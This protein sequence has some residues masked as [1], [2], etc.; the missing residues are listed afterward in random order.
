LLTCACVL[1]GCPADPKS[2]AAV[3][4][5]GTPDSASN[6]AAVSEHT[7][8]DSHNAKPDAG[9][10][11]PAMGGS[12]ADAGSSMTPPTGSEPKPGADAGRDQPKPPAADGGTPAADGGQPDPTGDAGSMLHEPVS[13]R[14]FLPTGEVQNTIRPQVEIDRAGGTH[15]LYPSYAGGDAYYAYC[16]KDCSGPDAMK[17]VRLPTDGTV[18]NA[19]LTLSAEGK[20]RALLATLLRVYYAQCDSDCSSAANWTVAAIVEHQGDQDVTGSALALDSAGHP[21]FLMHTYLAYLG[22][23]QKAPQTWFAQCDDACNTASSW[24]IDPIADQI[25]YGSQLRYDAQGRAHVA[26]GLVNADGNSGTDKLAAYFTC[27]DGCSSPD[28]WTGIGL[29]PLFESQSEEVRPSLAMALTKQ[30]GPRVVAL[31]HDANGQRRIVYLECDAACD[32]DHWASSVISDLKQLG[33]GVDIALDAQDHPHFAFTLDSNIGLYSCDASH[34]V[35]ETATWTLSK[36]EF[37][38]DLPHDDIILWPNCTI[39]AWVLQNPSVALG[40]DGSVRV[41]Y[42]ATDLSGGLSVIDPTKPACVAGKDMTLSRMAL[43]S[44]AL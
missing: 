18:G 21:R 32:D 41:A 26:T 12:K 36:I 42:E 15:A 2:T 28:A 7:S 17:V 9:H 27:A 4:D 31:D 1:A 34:C 6:D 44:S 22:I 43:L 40:G 25:W 38:S 11:Q 8:D 35:P 20:P 19:V 30:G 13:Q 37:S 14:F 10:D 23:G 39:D 24:R 33:S 3:D 16:A 5:A 29:T